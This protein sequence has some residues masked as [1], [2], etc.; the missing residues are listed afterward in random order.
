M[1]GVG[2]V[3][4]AVLRQRPDSLVW[5]SIPA[6]ASGSFVRAT[7]TTHHP[8]HDNRRG[9]ER[10]CG[11]A[12]LFK[13]AHSASA[14]SDH[15]SQRSASPGRRDDGSFCINCFISSDLRLIV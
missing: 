7:P 15:S 4:G 12:P 11:G 10:E 1:A 13:P 6:G 8:G 5:S 9:H 14:R 2:D 3:T